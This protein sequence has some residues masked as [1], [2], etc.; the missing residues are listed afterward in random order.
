M[1]IHLKYDLPPTFDRTRAGNLYRTHTLEL[2]RV[3]KS[4]Y[5]TLPVY[6]R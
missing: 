3:K 2:F 5:D 4:N 1:F 6:P